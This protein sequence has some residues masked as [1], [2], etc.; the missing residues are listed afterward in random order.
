MRKFIGP[1]SEYSSDLDQGAAV[2]KQ[3]CQLNWY[4]T[5][6]QFQ[7]VLILMHPEIKK[8]K[9]RRDIFCDEYI[10][11]YNNSSHL[12]ALNGSGKLGSTSKVKL[13]AWLAYEKVPLPLP[14][15]LYARPPLKARLLITVEPLV[16][17]VREALKENFW[18]VTDDKLEMLNDEPVSPESWSEVASFV[19]ESTALMVTGTANG[20]VKGENN[21]LSGSWVT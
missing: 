21:Y 19:R 7:Q 9:L 17:I 16:G 2:M 15:E 4:Q 14:S 12:T 3:S 10:K 1:L 11:R 18:N 8:G 13:V 6:E 5:V 20:V